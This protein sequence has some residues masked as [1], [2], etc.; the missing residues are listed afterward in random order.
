M[1][2]QVNPNLT[3]DQVKYRLMQSAKSAATDS[4]APVY[5]I[6]Q[7]GS[8]RV[9]APAAGAANQGFDLATDLTHSNYA[10]VTESAYHYQGAVQRVVRDNGDGYLYY[11]IDDNAQVQA[12][13]AS[14]F[15]D[16]NGVDYSTLAGSGMSWAG[17]LDPSV[18]TISTTNWVDE[19]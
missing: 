9:W 10:D 4:G 8:G 13:G 2:L 3:P 12:L 17:G 11:L 6:L 5:N 18:S 7:Q 15:A 16:K 14:Q 1:M 19:E